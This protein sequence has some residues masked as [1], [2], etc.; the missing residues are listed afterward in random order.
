[1]SAAPDSA[2]DRQSNP[3][4]AALQAVVADNPED[5]V[6]K[7]TLASSLEQAGQS[8]AAAELYQDIIAQDPDSVFA[9][10]AQKALA[11]LQSAISAPAATGLTPL[12]PAPLTPASAR[13]WD[14]VNFLNNQPIRRKQTLGFV[15]VSVVSVVAVAV[16]GVWIARES[17]R[18]Q[19]RNQA[20][21]EL[22]VAVTNYN[23]KSNELESGFRGQSDN[24]AII[25]TA[26]DYARRGQISPEQKG[27]LRRIL[28]N[29]AKNR[30]IEIATLVGADGRILASANRDRSG[31]PFDPDGLV[32]A[33]LKVPRRIATNLLLPRSELEREGVKLPASGLTGDVG[34]MR[35]VFVPVFDA[36][37]KKAVGVLVGGDLINGKTDQ[38]QQTTSSLGGGYTAIYLWE[39][40]AQAEAPGQFVLA[41]S[42]LQ[43]GTSPTVEPTF[44]IA[45]TQLDLL[46]QARLGTGDNLVG[47]LT[48]KNQPYT[49]AVKA[50]PNHQGQP[51]AFVVRGTPETSLNSLL[52]ESA[53]SQ[54][55]AGLIA[56]AAA[57][58]LG[59]LLSR[60]L[61]LPI[62]RLRESA[63]RLGTGDRF[64]RANVT[65]NDEVGEL[66]RTFNEM[67]DR[68]EDYTAAIE[69]QVKQRQQEAEFQRQERQ[70]LQEGVIRLLLDIEG[71]RQGDLTVEAQVDAGEVGSIADA[72]NVTLR[73]LQ[74]LVQQVQATA[75]QVRDSA[76]ANGTAVAELS[77]GATAQDRAIQTVTLS[78]QEIAAAIESV[79]ESAQ[80]AAEIAHLSRQAA[81]EG[82]IAADRTVASIDNIRGSVADTSKKAKR[83]AESSQEISKI[84]NIIYDISEKTNILAYNASIEAARAG[85][86]GQGFRQ[87]AEEVRQLA[88]QVTFSA[89]EIEQV[90]SSIQSE[91]AEMMRMME[92]STTQVVA[93]TQLV[94][95]TK[96]TLQGLAQISLEIDDLLSSISAAT[97]SQQE[98]SQRVTETMQEV[99]QVAQ[100]TASEAQ[101]VSTALQALVTI[102]LDLQ[103]SA[104]RFQ[105]DK[106]APETPNLTSNFWGSLSVSSS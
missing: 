68:M 87:V 3:E 98:S 105:V 77:V 95:Q 84:I 5:L 71:A 97:I 16:S 51:I 62:Q 45:L 66:A 36:S 75:N 17:G 67:A 72:F 59:L 31:D 92:D 85:E 78:V 57:A 41:T 76:I 25:E 6:A 12:S 61:T 18:T 4:I 54:A 106:S 20:I 86:Y 94:R 24:R 74:H 11:E 91:T 29:E 49:L 39:E 46:E 44:G 53:L 79:A 32:A 7:F 22:A 82:Q 100:I 26:G 103:A 13:W 23:G 52:Q 43:K 93:G 90:I 73:S 89:Q 42:V 60:A 55:I 104:S 40:V 35:L 81:Q 1:M 70:R 47:R 21:A 34:L 37:G 65:G 15:T 28:G 58:A 38:L 30:G 27:E 8:S 99:A 10:S 80:S 14:W 88:E 63:Q 56:V 64:V 19:L 33:V 50:L 101:S 9:A 69:E 48:L 102:A 96:E 83:L 2:S